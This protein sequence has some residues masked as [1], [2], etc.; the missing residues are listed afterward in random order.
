MWA[1]GQRVEARDPRLLPNSSEL[2]PPAVLARGFVL[3]EVTN[4][5]A[6]NC[7]VMAL[8]GAECGDVE[9]SAVI[10]PATAGNQPNGQLGSSDAVPRDGRLI[11]LASRPR[12]AANPA[13]RSLRRMRMR[14][15]PP[16]SHRGAGLD[17][18]GGS[19]SAF[20]VRSKRLETHLR[21]HIP[22]CP[23]IASQVA[24]NGRYLF[25]TLD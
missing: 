16:G 20:L 10:K 15:F 19:R 24:R 14:G 21:Y 22:Q 18:P 13:A 2:E 4:Q 25:G 17:S 8:L 5:A 12:S 1:D 6:G 3:S 7:P 11:L 9:L 23:L